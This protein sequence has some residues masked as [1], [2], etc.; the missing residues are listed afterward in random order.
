M[1]SDQQ[2]E[3]R[4]GMQQ[5]V[6]TPGVPGFALAEYLLH[7]IR[8][9]SFIDVTKCKITS[10]IKAKEFCFCESIIVVNH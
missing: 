5:G 3:L 9:K 2:S 4:G 7:I 10:S 8:T 1:S 6:S